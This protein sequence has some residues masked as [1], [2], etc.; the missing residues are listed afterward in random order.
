MS[1]P[2]FS[3]R[4]LLLTVAAVAVDMA[5]M[6]QVPMYRDDIVATGTQ[7]AF[8]S[9]TVIIIV[10]TGLAFTGLGGQPRLRAF[11]TGALVPLI[12]ML[13]FIAQQGGI[14]DI[15]V[16]LERHLNSRMVWGGVGGATLM[17]SKWAVKLFGFGIL[18]SIALGYLCVVFQWLVNPRSE[19]RP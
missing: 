15:A 1:R 5:L 13:Y 4:L 3:V 16:W 18:L 2:Q 8:L 10:S 7:V 19:K 11:C 14:A 12:L 9:F 17:E 6:L